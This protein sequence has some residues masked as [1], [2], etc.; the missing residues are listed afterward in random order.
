MQYGEILRGYVAD[1]EEL[2]PRFEALATEDVLSAIFDLLPPHP[3]KTLDIGAGTGR[4]AAWLARRSQ[5]VIAVEPA[6]ALRSAGE[7]LHYRPNLDWLDDRLPDLVR[8]KA[9]GETFNLVICIAVW[10][11]LPPEQHERGMLAL[12][13]LTA[14]GGRL[15]MS[16]RY[17]P[18]A[19]NRRCFAA[20]PEFLISTAEQAGLTSVTRRSAQSIQPGNRAA[21]VTWD[22]LCFDRP[23]GSEVLISVSG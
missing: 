4:D 6:D 5:H 21:G 8:T 1:A 15:I 19:P 17:G 14:P 11:H 12:A 7:A 10:Q 2:I 18:G 3:G 22:W 9:R 13:S 16:L 20:D 23:M